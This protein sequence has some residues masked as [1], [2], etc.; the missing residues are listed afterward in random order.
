[1]KNFQ[2]RYPTFLERDFGPDLDGKYPLHA[3]SREAPAG[4]RHV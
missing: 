2:V 4:G 1:M 3:V